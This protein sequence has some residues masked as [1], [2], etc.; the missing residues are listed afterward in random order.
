MSR[1]CFYLK[2]KIYF[3]YSL[4]ICFF[5]T[6]CVTQEMA[7]AKRLEEEA[8]KPVTVTGEVSY[9]SD[10][11]AVGNEV[12]YWFDGALRRLS[13]PGSVVSE[14]VGDYS[15][16]EELFYTL[17]D[18]TIRS[19]NPTTGEENIIYKTD[20]HDAK[21]ICIA[22]NYL[23]FGNSGK[24]C[25][26]NLSD[27]SITTLSRVFTDSTNILT[28]D[29][30]IMYFYFMNYRDGKIYSHNIETGEEKVVYKEFSESSYIISALAQGDTL[31]VV[32]TLGY[33]YSVSGLLTGELSEPELLED[34]FAKG[35]VTAIAGYDG[36]IYFTCYTRQH[37]L[38]LWR[39]PDGG[40]AEK[41][42]SWEDVNYYFKY[43]G[44]LSA[45]DSL[46]ACCVTTDEKC[47][48]FTYELS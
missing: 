16:D 23:V 27:L 46:V 5:L 15:E 38:D 35:T 9:I 13:A 11:Y 26:L 12:Y 2:A 44:Q 29:S 33:I 17:A 14:Y 48:I 34:S 4:A 7:E 24:S 39:L 42:A 37:T 19:Y 3:L 40:E 25:A 1:V 36:G 8:A 45:S 18:G 41:L 43:S 21:I 20:L 6:G 10:I 47:R 22:D 31:Y 32:E 28:F 30:G